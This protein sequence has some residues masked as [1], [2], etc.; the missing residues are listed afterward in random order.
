MIT[1]NRNYLGPSNSLQI[2]ILQCKWS[3]LILLIIT[4]FFPEMTLIFPNQFFWYQLTLSQTSP[5]FYVSAVQ[6]FWKHCGKRRNCS[7]QAISSFPTVFSFRLKNRLPFLANLKLS[8]AKPLSLEAVTILE[9]L[10]CGPTAQQSKNHGP[11]SQG[12]G[13]A[14]HPSPKSILRI[15]GPLLDLSLFQISFSLKLVTLWDLRQEG[16]TFI[17]FIVIFISYKFFFCHY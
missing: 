8:S 4:L 17:L 11:Y 16:L 5:V 15:L 12:H 3:L 9:F 2:F 10:T 6:I 1:T 14:R 13:T 7:W